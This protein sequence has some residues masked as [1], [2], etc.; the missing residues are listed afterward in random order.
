MNG[1]GAASRDRHRARHDCNHRLKRAF[2]LAARAAVR[3]DPIAKTCHQRCTC[4]GLN[5]CEAVKRVARRMSDLVYVLLKSGK[6]YDR[7][8]VEKC[9][10]SLSSTEVEAQPPGLARETVTALLTRDRAD[11]APSQLPQEF[12]A[13]Q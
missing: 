4:R 2:Y 6:A 10:Q 11:G 3:H 13:V 8:I 7:L 9:Q 5:Y 1:H 12:P